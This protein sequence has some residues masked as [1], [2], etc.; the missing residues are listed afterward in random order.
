MSLSPLELERYSRQIPIAGWGVEGQRRLKG[1]EVV[2]VGIGG[3]GCLSSLYLAA[4]GVGRIILVDKER[5]ELNNMNRQILCWHDD[6][7]RFKAEV[8]KEKL[9]AFNPEIEVEAVVS[10][11]TEGNVKEIVGEADVVVDGLDNWGTRFIINEYCVRESVPFVHAGASGMC[12][13]IT[14]IIPIEGPCLRCIFPEAPPEVENV[15]VLGA[16]PAFLASL[17]VMETVKLI[18]GIGTPLVGRILFIE[19][20]EMTVEDVK[21]K[22]TADC[23]VCGDL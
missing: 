16:T 12:G 23:P 3:L 8:A 10:E 18:T 22:R 9:E 14:T 15:P 20:E 4:A 17:Q 7:G 5:F 6:L 11:V 21:I 2:V 13:Q 1:A 19:G